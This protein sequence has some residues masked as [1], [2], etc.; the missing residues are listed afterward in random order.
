MNFL[1]VIIFIYLV[2]G[3]VTVPLPYTSLTTHNFC[4][5]WNFYLKFLEDYEIC[6]NQ[7]IW[8]KWL[9]LKYF[10]SFKKILYAYLWIA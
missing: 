1:V 3:S 9:C 10:I 4:S 7:K 5:A 8:G 6:I 2:G